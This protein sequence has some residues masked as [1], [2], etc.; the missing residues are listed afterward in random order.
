MSDQ[1]KCSRCGN[2][3]PAI[4]GFIGF[5]G[6]L[7]ERIRENACA[8]CWSEWLGYQ[9]MAINEYRLN[10]GTEAHRAILSQL[11]GEYMKLPGIAVGDA[12]GVTPSIA[13]IDAVRSPEKG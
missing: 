1:V 4:T 3:G 10:L 7:K 12:S 13:H 5:P 6:E 11:V 8:D 9:L 2:Q